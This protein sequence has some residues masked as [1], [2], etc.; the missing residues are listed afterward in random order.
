MQSFDPHSEVNTQVYLADETTYSLQDVRDWL[1][2]PSCQLARNTKIAY[3]GAINRCCRILRKT[4]KDIVADRHDV[5]AHFPIENYNPS[6]AKSPKA[7]ERFLR[8]LGCAINQALGTKAKKQKLRAV[9]DGWQLLITALQDY[10]RTADKPVFSEMKIIG[11]IALADMARKLD[12]DSQKIDTASGLTILKN[13][14]DY[15][16]R[17]ALRG[18]LKFIVFLQSSKSLKLGTALPSAPVEVPSGRL[19]NVTSVIPGHLLSELQIFVDIAARGIWSVTDGAYVDNSERGPIENAAKKVIATL[20]ETL[21]P[22]S[23]DFVSVAEAFDKEQLTACVQTWRRWHQERDP[24]ALD[25]STAKRY[26]ER[27]AVL[28]DRNG[29]SSAATRSILRIDRWLN[30]KK[31]ESSKMPLH[32]RTFCRRIM[33]NKSERL[34]LLTLHVSMRKKAQFHLNQIRRLER[35]LESKPNFNREKYLKEKLKHET[36]ARQYG[37]CAALAAIEIGAC[38]VRISNAIAITYQGDD[39]WLDL[40]ASGSGSGHLFIPGSFVKN[41]NE[42]SAPILA[43]N[44]LRP[45]KTLLWYEKHIRPLFHVNRNSNHFFPAV[46]AE[47]RPLSYHTLKGWWDRIIAEFGFPGMNPHMF[48]HTQASILVARRPGNWTLISV[49]LGDTEATCRA[50]YAWIDQEGLMLEGQ[51][52]L[53]EEFF[54][55]A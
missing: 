33:M 45:L 52:I 53:A 11:V 4:P 24:R 32:T 49:R 39:R 34:R 2:G 5:L 51:N 40:N 44:K 25:P 1:D 55:A 50:F 47:N 31:K 48:R 43:S 15:K 35:K 13:A 14:D 18:A 12:I 27:L 7:A 3:E 17:L 41:K 22:S 19:N 46:K 21:D 54:N 29:E 28:Q 26:I 42:I 38:P 6:W 30:S 10:L 8:N 9:N 37:T 20:I 23:A 36:K 16:H